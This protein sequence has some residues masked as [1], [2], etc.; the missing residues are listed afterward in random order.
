MSSTYMSINNRK[1]KN[2]EN[3]QRGVNFALLK[4]KLS[5]IVLSL[6]NQDLGACLRP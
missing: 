5:K 3:E 2:I 6:A 4:P 1:A